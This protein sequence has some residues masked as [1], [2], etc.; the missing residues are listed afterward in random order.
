M[1]QSVPV[2]PMP[3]FNP[4]AEV[5][6]SVATRWTMWLLDFEMFL[7][8]SGITDTRHQQ[9]LPSTLQDQEFE[10]FLNKFSTAEKTTI[11]KRQR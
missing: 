10:K 7:L 4:D 2:Q 9:D 8:A 11:S 6:A 5:G 3:E 1:A